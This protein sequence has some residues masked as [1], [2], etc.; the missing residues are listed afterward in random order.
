MQEELSALLPDEVR[1][2]L[3]DRLLNLRAKNGHSTLELK[4]QDG[5]IITY[6]EKLSYKVNGR[7][8][9]RTTSK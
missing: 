1:T 9:I 2:W 3:E 7:S 6:H 4:V 8:R 5:H